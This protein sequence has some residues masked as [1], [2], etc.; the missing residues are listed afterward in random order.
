M[1]S[2][3]AGRSITFVEDDDR[4]LMKQVLKQQGIK[5]QERVLNT[6]SIR[7]WVRKIEGLADEVDQLVQVMPSCIA[8]DV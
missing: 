8:L 5:L 7:S 1:L 4:K 2:G 3:Q 6:A